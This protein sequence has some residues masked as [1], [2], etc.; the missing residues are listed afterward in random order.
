M[1]ILRPSPCP[2]PE[3]EGE[4]AQL[5][6]FIAAYNSYRFNNGMLFTSGGAGMAAR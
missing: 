5:N 1:R 3:G 4:F 2:L 6:L